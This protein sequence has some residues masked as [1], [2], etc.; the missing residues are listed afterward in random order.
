METHLSQ[1][2]AACAFDGQH[3][4]SS[5]ISTIVADADVAEDGISGDAISSA[6]ACV[7]ASIAMTGRDTGANTRPTVIKTASIRRMAKAMF[8]E[9]GSHKLAAKESSLFLNQFPNHLTLIGIKCAGRHSCIH[10]FSAAYLIVMASQA[11][12]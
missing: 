1:S 7:E 6:M 3:C 4:M 5:G 11:Y 8:T 2:T 9:T 10:L 12:S